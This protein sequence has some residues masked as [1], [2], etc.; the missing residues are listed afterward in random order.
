MFIEEKIDTIEHTTPQGW[1]YTTMTLK[2]Y[3]HIILSGLKPK[4]M[5]TKLY[6]TLFIVMVGLV[7]G[8]GQT[9]YVT[10]YNSNSVS[11]IDVPTKTVTATISCLDP[12]GVSFSSDG[13]KVYV[14]NKN[15]NTIRVINTATNIISGT[16]SVGGNPV[17]FGNFISN[18]TAPVINTGS[19]STLLCSGS[20]ISVPFIITDTLNPG[21]IFT[22]QLSDASGSFASPVNI[23]TLADTVSGTI[24]A[25]IPESTPAGTGYRIRVT[26]SN[27]AATGTDSGTDITVHALPTVTYNQSPYIVYMMR[28]F[29]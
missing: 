23:G 20:N 3:K 14:A 6:L 8:L 2:F 27:P 29:H 5:K 28:H 15:S 7:R 12:F 11:I 24:T 25:T 10:N 9:A 26:S 13:T 22:A 21:N 17:A 19:V 16:N 1:Q 18:H 4:P